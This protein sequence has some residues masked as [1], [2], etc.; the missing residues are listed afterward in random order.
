MF[1]LKKFF[2]FQVNIVFHLAA[3]VRFDE[4]IK[5][6]LLTN[7]RATRDIFFF[8]QKMTKLKS[9]MYVST[10]YSNCPLKTIEE[11]IYPPKIHYENLID[12]GETLQDDNV[13][14]VTAEYVK[15]AKRLGLN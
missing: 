5:T 10:I 11:K 9:I 4:A 14:T 8:A 12:L 15:N 1:N 7:V 13:D 2:L 3:T 6:A